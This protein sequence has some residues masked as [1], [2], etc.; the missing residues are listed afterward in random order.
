MYQLLK[1]YVHVCLFYCLCYLLS[2]EVFT[3]TGQSQPQRM[4]INISQGSPP[5]VGMP[6]PGMPMGVR[7]GPRFMRPVAPRNE[8]GTQTA[9]GNGVPANSGTQTPGKLVC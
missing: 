2:Y 4:Q 7:L 3:F 1:R 9:G 5:V 8:S 6:R